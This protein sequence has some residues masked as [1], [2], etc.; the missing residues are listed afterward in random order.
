MASDPEDALVYLVVSVQ[1]VDFAAQVTYTEVEDN[2]RLIDRAAVVLDDP[3]GA[4]GDIPREGQILKI[5]LGWLT[6][7]AVLFE[8][9]IIRVVTEGYGATARRVT[10][11]ALDLSYR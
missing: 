7:H 3:K 10:L 8:G 5:E 1:G 9:E 4:V 11:V 6:E 2:D